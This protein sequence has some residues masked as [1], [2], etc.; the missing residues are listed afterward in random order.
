MTLAPDCE[1]K[2]TKIEEFL[3][4]CGGKTLGQTKRYFCAKVR[5]GQYCHDVIKNQ[6]QGPYSQHMIFFVTYEWV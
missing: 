5:G 1:E 6:R 2:A 3:V 4:L